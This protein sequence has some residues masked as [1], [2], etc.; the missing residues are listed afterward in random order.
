ME[1]QKDR[2]IVARAT[3]RGKNSKGGDRTQIYLNTE[4]AAA[5]V[6]TLVAAGNNPNGV[7]IDMHTSEKVN[8]HTGRPFESTILFVRPV[9]D[10]PGGAGARAPGKFIDSPTSP[11]STKPKTNFKEQQVKG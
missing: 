9:L 5:L 11:T 2:M 4:E 6:D 1:R 7:K 10:A 3:V 8:S